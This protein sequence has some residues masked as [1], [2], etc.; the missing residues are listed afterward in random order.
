M[1][2]NREFKVQTVPV[3]D[4]GDLLAWLRDP[5]AL[6]WV[7]RGDGLEY[8]LIEAS[9]SAA[10]NAVVGVPIYQG[11]GRVF[12]AFEAGPRVEPRGR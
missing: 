2:P 9:A 3:T 12:R 1:R 4:P 5:G 6:A 11:F 10:A 8:G 7:R